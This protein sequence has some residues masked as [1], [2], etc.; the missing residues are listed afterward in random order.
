M[1]IDKDK[2]NIFIMDKINKLKDD[3]NT[4]DIS[5][6]KVRAMIN[7]LDNHYDIDK[8]EYLKTLL[9]PETVR[10]VKIP[11]K[12]PVPTC[13]FQMHRTLKFYTSEQG[14][15]VMCITPFI[16]AGNVEGV[17]SPKYS[18]SYYY[19]KYFTGFYA[20]NSQATLNGQDYNNNAWK[21]VVD[22]SMSIPD[23]YTHYRLVS[24]VVTIRYTGSLE[25]A[26]GVIGGAINFE[27]FNCLTG[28][29]YMSSSPEY[30]P[31]AYLNL[32]IV[33]TD[34][35]KYSQFELI[36]DCV[37]FKENSCIEGLR[38]IY[39]PIDKDK[40]EFKRILRKSD[41]YIEKNTLGICLKSKIP[42]PD[43]F[44]WLIYLQGC[45]VGS[46][47]NRNFTLDWYAN[48]ECIPDPKYLNFLPV[49]LN[50]YWIDQN[51]LEAIFEEVKAA[52]LNKLNKNYILNFN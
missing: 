17:R 14:T 18:G 24:A 41:L 35:K 6:S 23:L 13:C 39:F 44:N 50:S 5:L 4:D 12:Y 26:K 40:L 28:Y 29:G 27:K 10:A 3:L 11:S 38:M 52:C 34:L 25:E 30:N 8:N 2:N 36:R 46:A 42:V 37:Y 20:Y 9:N 32:H 16:L 49:Q 19:L 47:Q 7:E 15:D 45:P 21:T 48:F 51:I 1:I 31:N 33:T 43:G 22:A